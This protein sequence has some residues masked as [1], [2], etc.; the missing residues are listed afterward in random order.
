MEFG[1]FLKEIRIKQGLSM[2]ELERRSKVSQA[3]ISQI[4]KGERHPKPE[5][6][7]KLAKPLDISY[8]KLM[9][10]AGYIVQ[11]DEFTEEELAFLSDVEAGKPL[12]DLMKHKPIIDD[13]EV[14]MA[15]LEFAVDIIRSLRKKEEKE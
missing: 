10:A 4:E 11:D 14:T 5:I 2:R 6:I 13:K 12:T 3:Y 1:N 9:N 15:E 8:V 7:F